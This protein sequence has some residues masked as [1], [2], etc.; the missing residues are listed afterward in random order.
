MTNSLEIRSRLEEKIDDEIRLRV[1]AHKKNILRLEAS[2]A[3]VRNLGVKVENRPLVLI[4][5]GDSWFDYPLH[6]NGPM[7]GDTDV[8]SHLR[9]IGVM[10]PTI[11]NL[12]VAG[13]TAVNVMSLKRQSALIEQIRDKSNWIEGK[14]DAILFSAGG[15]DI[16]GDEFCL[17]LDFNDGRSTGLNEERFEKSLGMVEA[18]YLSL[19]ALR[20]RVAPGVPVFGHCYDFPIPNGSHPICAGPWLKP[21]LD[22]CNWSVENGVSIV[23]N[24]L[25]AFR[26]MLKKLE[27]DSS[28]NFH[29]VDTQGILKVSDWANELHPYP[30]GFQLIAQKF[31]DVLASKLIKMVR[32]I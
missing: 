3:T 10:P 2:Q 29:L 4:A 11:L 8:I 28:N 1:V 9:R 14:P 19:F 21:S 24:A 23:R 12:A 16:A 15:N 22:F 31:S 18:C 5:Q 7:I 26:T 30:S 27:S 32:P 25:L 6:G 17:F 20:D 13:D